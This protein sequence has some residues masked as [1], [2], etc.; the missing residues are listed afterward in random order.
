V[1]ATGWWFSLGSPVPSTNKN[2][3]RNITEI[4]LKVALKLGGGFLSIFLNIFI[5][6]FKT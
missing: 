2:D 1:I 5:Y 3:R 4:L 6:K